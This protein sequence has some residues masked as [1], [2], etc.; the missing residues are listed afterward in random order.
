MHAADVFDW[1]ERLDYNYGIMDKQAFRSRAAELGFVR[2]A[3][4]SAEPFSG[5]QAAAS[6]LRAPPRLFEDPKEIMPGAKSIAVLLYPYSPLLRAPGVPPLS[7]YYFGEH[8]SYIAHLRLQ[9]EFPSMLKAPLPS[10]RAAERAFPGARGANGLVGIVE[11]GTR[12][13]IQLFINDAFEPDEPQP[14]AAPCARCGLCEKA[15]PVGAING[16]ALDANRCLRSFL[17]GGVMP[18]EVKEKLPTLLG[19]EICQSVC[20]RNA[21]ERAVSPSEA[22]RAAFSYDTL[23]SQAASLAPARALVGG[24]VSAARLRSQAIVLAARE[25]GYDDK[26]A[27]FLDSEN[28]TIRDAANWALR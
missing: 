20:P 18:E 27:A 15:C 2:A 28:E 9:A 12:V 1:P 7:G 22:I 23:L 24:N 16:G 14:Q 10:K 13:C 4:V 3:F 19:C 25:G 26:I 5:W 17:H 6:G 8:A 11:Y 21:N